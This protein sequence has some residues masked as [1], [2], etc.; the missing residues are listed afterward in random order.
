MTREAGQATKVLLM[1]G[2]MQL[3]E[4]VCH[5]FTT[6]PTGGVSPK[7]ASIAPYN[8]AYFDTVFILFMLIAGFNFSLH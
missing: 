7:N 8:S 2:G 1:A 6:M 4:A 5:T 3:Y